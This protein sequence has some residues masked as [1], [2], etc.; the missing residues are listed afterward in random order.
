MS[1]HILRIGRAE[2][3]VLF[4]ASSPWPWWKRGEMGGSTGRRRNPPLLPC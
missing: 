4:K 3:E 1:R 2:Q